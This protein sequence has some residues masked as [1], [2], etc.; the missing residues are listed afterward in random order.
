MHLLMSNAHLLCIVQ[1]PAAQGRPETPGVSASLM[2]TM[3]QRV[4]S[5]GA[6]VREKDTEITALRN[7]VREECE[8]RV[9]LMGLLS[10]DG[11]ARR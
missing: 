10:K 6:M 9:R 8:E 5:L 4:L 11:G 3:E 7:T 2:A 1:K